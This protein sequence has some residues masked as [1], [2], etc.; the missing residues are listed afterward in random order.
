MSTGLTGI[1]TGA[2]NIPEPIPDWLVPK[3]QHQEQE[4]QH[5]GGASTIVR[6]PRVL[7]CETIAK[8]CP[9]CLRRFRASP[10]VTKK[11]TRNRRRNSQL[12]RR[13]NR[14]RRNEFPFRF[15]YYEGSRFVQ[16]TKRN[17]SNCS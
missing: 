12:R 15:S 2:S 6:Q 11:V 4:E 7:T 10:I 16:G 1:S 5:L 9:T 3:F 17:F 8:V 13:S 14:K